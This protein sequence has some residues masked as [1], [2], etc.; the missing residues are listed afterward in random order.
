MISLLFEHDYCIFGIVYLAV[1]LP[2]VL[3]IVHFS[4]LVILYCD[5]LDILQANQLTG[6]PTYF[7]GRKKSLCLCALRLHKDSMNLT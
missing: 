7:L 3:D 2:A 4:I 5:K 1:S 6:Q